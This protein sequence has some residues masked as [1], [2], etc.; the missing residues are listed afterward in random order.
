MKIFILSR[1]KS[2]PFFGTSTSVLAAPGA[3][4]TG[5]E[6]ELTWLATDRLTVGGN[7]SYTPNEYSEDLFILDPAGFDAPASLFGAATVQKNIKGNQLLA[8]SR[9]KKFNGWVSHV[10][11]LASG[12]A[13]TFSG[14]YSWIDDVY[15]SP[16]EN[17]DEMAQGL[18]TVRHA[19]VLDFF[20]RPNDCFR[21]YKQRVG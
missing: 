17:K 5:M 14:S 9:V 2:V 20:R 6:A 1:L 8:G 4:I 12:S 13:L 18:R 10:T 11:P 3:E 15:Y 21:V 7:F 16:F 19:R